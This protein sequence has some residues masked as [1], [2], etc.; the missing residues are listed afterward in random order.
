MTAAQKIAAWFAYPIVVERYAGATARGPSF[1][2]PV[3]VLGMVDPG[4]KWVSAPTG[5]TVLSSARVFLPSGTADVPAQSRITLPAV[6]GGRV[7]RVITSASFAST[8][9][10]PDHL[11]VTLA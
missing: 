7:T 2:A 1:D 3:T 8:R 10:T 6:F 5:E 11:E 4:T 9:G